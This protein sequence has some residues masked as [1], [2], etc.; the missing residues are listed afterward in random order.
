LHWTPF[1]PLGVAHT[2]AHTGPMPPPGSKQRFRSGKPQQSPFAA[3]VPR[4]ETHPLEPPAP[5]TPPVPAQ[6]AAGAHALD[7]LG[8]PFVV[9]SAQHPVAHDALETQSG[10]HVPEPVPKLTQCTL[11]G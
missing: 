7:P 5:V 6:M 9:S 10:V 2:M 11:A 3:Q 1:G 8:C 4:S